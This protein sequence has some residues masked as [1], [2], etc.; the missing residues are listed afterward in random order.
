MTVIRTSDGWKIVDPGPLKGPLSTG[1]R[2]V[3]KGG[4]E[5]S[6]DITCEV[7]EWYYR[8]DSSEYP[9]LELIVKEVKPGWL[10]HVP[11]DKQFFRGILTAFLVF[12][13]LGSIAWTFHVE[14][15]HTY[16]W[17]FAGRQIRWVVGLA[18]FFVVGLIIPSRLQLGRGASVF[19][20][21]FFF[22]TFFYAGVALAVVWLRV[23]AFPGP[24]PQ[25]DA[26][27]AKY[28]QALASRFSTSYWP[29]VLAALPWI[30][31]ALKAFGLELAA[32]ATELI[33]KYKHR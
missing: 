1:L 33:G 17:A 13:L 15:N 19:S 25:N 14:P 4:P 32:K 3:I 30:T 10:A 9:Y 28:A 22:A 6:G 27:Y 5:A 20:N 7:K 12:A 31:L 8:V 24:L 23:A 18:L 21:A 11:E 26:D 29:L 2:I 16:E